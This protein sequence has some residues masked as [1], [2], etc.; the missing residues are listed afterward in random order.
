MTDTQ[1]Q[2]TP[3]SKGKQ[4]VETEGK[5]KARAEREQV[6]LP[7]Q[8]KIFFHHLSIKSKELI[9][10]SFL[11]YYIYIYTALKRKRGYRGGTMEGIHFEG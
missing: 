4:T 9:H 5:K 6:F 8:K 1:L 3:V 2:T 11:L 7:F 10:T